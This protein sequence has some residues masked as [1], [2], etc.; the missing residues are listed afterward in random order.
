LLARW[1][2]W[3]AL[4]IPSAGRPDVSDGKRIRV[5]ELR[6]VRGTGGGPEKTVLLGAAIADRSRFEVIVCYIRDRRDR[7]FHIDQRA[8]ALG[9]EYVEVDERHSMD[10]L[11]IPALVRI[12]RSRQID[13]V[14]AHEYKTDLVALVL[15]KLTRVVPLA[16]AHGWTGNS[17]RELKVYYP[18]DKWLLTRYPRVVAVSSQIK[19]ELVEHGARSERV[20]VIL[21]SIDPA[22]FKRDPMKEAPIRASLGFAPTDIVIGSVGRVE[23]QKRFDLLLEAVQPIMAVRPELRVAIVGDGSL[24]NEI[25]Q[26]ADRLGV[27]D[28][29]LFTGHRGD[30]ADLHHAFDLFVQSSDYEGTPNAVLEAMAM[31][32]PLVATEAGGT[33]ELAQD[34]IHALLTPCGDVPAIRSAVERALD[35]PAE[36]KARALAARQR[37][38]T[39]LSFEHRTRTLERIYAEIARA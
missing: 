19:Q 36:T 11:I 39:D 33:A 28:R 2:S 17:P 32:T 3:R 24:L 29:C 16:T 26:V 6:S 5:L 1:P 25:R 21:N 14:H 15:S 20:T 31:E 34:G 38:E 8:K 22:Q 30:I 27:A 18:A 9:V 37:I 12:I 10:P 35:R 13:I 7:A 23:R 4:T